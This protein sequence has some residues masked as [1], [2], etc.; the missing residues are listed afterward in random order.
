MKTKKSNLLYLI[1]P[2]GMFVVIHLIF[3]YIMWDLNPSNWEIKVRFLSAFF[4]LIAIVAGVLVTENV[5]KK[6]KK[7]QN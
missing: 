2:F 3:S 7:Q 4:G 5:I 6:Q 1:L